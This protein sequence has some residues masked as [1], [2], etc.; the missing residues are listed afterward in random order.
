M[1]LDKTFWRERYLT[2][3]TGWDLGGPSTP[4]REYIDQLKDKNIRI[5]IPGAGRAYEAE[6]LHNRGFTRVYVI[7]LA[8]EP[9]TDL[10]KRCP[11]FPAEH[12]LVGDFFKHI[13]QYDLI[14]EQ[15]FFCALD[16]AL[17]EAYVKKMHELL[18]P[19]G[20]L[21]GVLFNDPLNDDRPP[22]G[23]SAEIYEPIFSKHF[24][25]LSFKPCYNSIKPREGRELWLSAVKDQ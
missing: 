5:L 21:T 22:F 23:G 12:L 11:T 16:P 25:S 9:F 2:N 1:S 4:L 8:E 14:L 3:D 20:K 19:G 18:A 6:Y 10:K 13:G 17:R 15:T 24:R 7:D